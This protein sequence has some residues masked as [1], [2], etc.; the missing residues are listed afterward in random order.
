MKLA[1]FN[2]VLF[3]HY[4]LIYKSSYFVF[5]CIVLRCDDLI[6]KEH[7]NVYISENLKKLNK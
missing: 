7:N 3:Y 2:F 5:S 6:S 1:V 4:R